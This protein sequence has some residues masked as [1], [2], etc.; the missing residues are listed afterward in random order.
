MSKV[1]FVDYDTKQKYTYQSVDELANAVMYDM[2]IPTPELDTPIWHVRLGSEIL[3]PGAVS[4]R[5]LNTPI[6]T[7]EDL[8]LVLGLDY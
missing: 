7:F 5:D 4:S 3:F 6:C 8:L 1:S 2:E